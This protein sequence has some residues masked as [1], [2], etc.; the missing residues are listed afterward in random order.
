MFVEKQK[1]RC[2]TEVIRIFK[3]LGY[4]NNDG[5]AKWHRIAAILNQLIFVHF[6]L[7]AQGFEVIESVALRKDFFK[8][9]Q[10]MFIFWSICALNL[11]SLWFFMRRVKI[12][13]IKQNIEDFMIEFD[14][15]EGRNVIAAEKN[16]VKQMRYYMTFSIASITALGIASFINVK[17]KSGKSFPLNLWLPFSDF[18]SDFKFVTSLIFSMWFGYNAFLNICYIDFSVMNSL[19][20]LRGVVLDYT[21]AISDM[22]KLA[23]MKNSL[24][25]TIKL[26]QIY[27]EINENLSGIALPQTVFG[28]IIFCMIG[29]CCIFVCILKFLSTTYH[30]IYSLLKSVTRFPR[31]KILQNS[32]E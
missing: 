23:N 8:T 26:R 31:L 27:L 19:E 5:N 3:F 25:F 18:E 7:F 30:N 21:E 29:Y 20:L 24:N 28:S 2:W 11:R 15:N 32:L 4:L 9:I 13:Q 12:L 22:T 16:L 10:C 17:A 6:I 14:L 1:F